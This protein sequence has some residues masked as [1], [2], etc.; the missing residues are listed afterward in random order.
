MRT[1]SG[2]VGIEVVPDDGRAAARDLVV[3]P[4]DDDVAR[5]VL[6]D[7]RGDLP[8]EVPDDFPADDFPADDFGAAGDP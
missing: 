2:G 6:A 3:G 7:F 8:V 4:F 1:A 5:S